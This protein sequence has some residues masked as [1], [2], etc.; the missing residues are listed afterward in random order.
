MKSL[1]VFVVVAAVLSNA[2]LSRAEDGELTRLFPRVAELA[3]SGGLCRLDVPAAV[4]SEAQPDFSDV[5]IVGAEG[6]EVPFLIDQVQVR[7]PSDGPPPVA[8]LVPTDITRQRTGLRSVEEVRV[9][10]PATPLPPGATWNI[11]VDSAAMSF[12]RRYTLTDPEGASLAEGSVFR[13]QDPLRARLDILLPNGQPGAEFRI[14]FDGEIG[15]FAPSFQ[16]QATGMS[17]RGARL[18]TPLVLA[19]LN[20]ESE[21]TTIELERPAGVVPSRLRFTTTSSFFARRVHV[22][23]VREGR[24]PHEIGEGDIF[25]AQE[26]G[27]EYL[28]VQLSRSSGERLRVVIEDGDSPS[29]AGIHIVSLTLQPSLFYECAEDQKLYFGGGRAGQPRYDTQR[30]GGTMLG[31]AIARREYTEASVGDAQNNV[32]FDDGPALAYLMRAGRVVDRSQFTTSVPVFVQGAREGVSRV[33][34]TVGLL[35]RAAADLHDVRIVDAEGQQWPYV[36]APSDA[37]VE[38]PLLVERAEG[39]SST[40]VYAL[41]S[42]EGSVELRRLFVTT[43]SDFVRRPFELRGI[44]SDDSYITLARGELSHGPDSP[45]RMEIAMDHRGP[46]ELVV[47]DGNDA[48]LELE[49]VG[50]IDAPVFYLIAPDGSYELLAG[51][52]IEPPSYEVASALPLILATAV[53]RARVGETADN[54]AF[55]PP[56]VPAR[57][58]TEEIVVW[59]VLLFGVLILGFFTWRA[60]RESPELES[61]PSSSGAGSGAGSSEGSNEPVTPQPGTSPPEPGDPST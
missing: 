2:S 1:S 7:W 9:R 17:R 13:L 28:E 8:R 5:R 54:P 53:G 43:T 61:P 59:A 14:R 34:P 39:E 55:A 30:F 48:P 4:L 11:V 42:P 50:V 40:S 32:G 15:H 58:E 6:S 47:Q 23:D 38:V 51:A 20:V 31:E 12:V 29:L 27:A 18:E 21:S 10:L 45:Q 16:I 36:R 52:E 37:K 57:F 41:S 35:A 46:M 26:A 24:E 19:D 44:Q 49:V 3:G 33:E 56:P 22:F 60:A 25:R